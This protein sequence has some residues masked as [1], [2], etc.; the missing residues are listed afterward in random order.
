MSYL[1]TLI[2]IPDPI[3]LILI[4]VGLAFIYLGSRRGLEPLM[5]VPIG[6]GI[7]LA[8]IPLSGLNDPPFGLLYL[9]REKLLMTEVLPCLA[10]LTIGTMM[11][12]RPLLR[13][14]WL[15]LFGIS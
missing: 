4:A 6:F 11:D 7:V 3:S 14:P 15:L 9:I 2:N 13:S 8:N 1:N 12:L 10:F 5:L